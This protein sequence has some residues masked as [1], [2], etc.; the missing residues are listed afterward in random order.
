VEDTMCLEDIE[1]V[2]NLTL[3]ELML[4]HGSFRRMTTTLDFVQIEF[5]ALADDDEVV[6]TIR[7]NF[8]DLA[9][10]F[11]WKHC[12]VI[13]DGACRVEVTMKKDGPL[14]LLTPKMP[15]RQPLL[16]PEEV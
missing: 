7:E 11:D 5:A 15:R 8:Q 10:R 3:D 13:R 12:R 16:L 4:G 14:R 2:I 9:Q 6:E 1:Q